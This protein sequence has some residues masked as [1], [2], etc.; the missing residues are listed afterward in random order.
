MLHLCTI[1]TI[2]I[3]EEKKKIIAKKIPKFGGLRKRKRGDT[4]N[5]G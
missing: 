3:I 4:F 5:F 1:Q 2:H